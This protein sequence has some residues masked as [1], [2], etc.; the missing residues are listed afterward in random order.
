MKKIFVFAMIMMMLMTT[1]ALAA[2]DFGEQTLTGGKS[3]LGTL[4]ERAT[5][6][7]G[8]LQWI[9]YLVAIGMVIWVGIRYLISGAGEK[10][11]AKET[12]VPV[13]IGAILVAGATWIASTLFQAMK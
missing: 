2:N 9:G 12:L 10:A 4:G 5:G 13:V 3:S 11:K 1:F 6:F 8:T 7:L